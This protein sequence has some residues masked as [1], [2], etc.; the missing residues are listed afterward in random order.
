MA[1]SLVIHEIFLSLQGESTFAGLPCVFVR[2]TGC[3]LRC[4]WCD[5]A[6]AFREGTRQ[7][8]AQVLARVEQLAQPFRRATGNGRLPLIEITGGEPLLQPGARPLLRALCD[9]G[10]TVLLETSGAEDISTVDARAHRIMDLKCPAS[11]EE[12]RNRWEN[13]RHLT[14]RDELKLV[15]ASHED[16]EWARN[17]LTERNLA[18]LCPVL[19]SW[20]MPSEVPPVQAAL[21]PFPPD[22]H[23]ITRQ[24]LAERILADALPVRFQLQIHKF[25]WPPDARGV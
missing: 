4:A 24:Q 6:D 15:I 3:N 25:I 21:K 2:L 11:G 23:P 17:V 7:S 8:Q 9:A 20:A 10:W 19:I 14:P 18:A 1:E 12:G 5:T 22:H 16:Y 13:L